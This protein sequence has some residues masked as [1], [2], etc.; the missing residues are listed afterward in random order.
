MTVAT[1]HAAVPLGARLG[2]D[3]LAVAVRSTAATAIELC[4]ARPGG[5]EQRVALDS[6]GETFRTLIAGIAPGQRYGLRAHGPFDPARGHRFD[7]GRLLL[8]PYAHAIDGAYAIVLADLPEACTSH[9]RRAWSETVIY[10]AHVRGLTRL[11]PAIAP[12]LRGTYAGLAQPA[13][14]EELLALG[15]TAIELMPTF[16][17]RSEQHLLQA[18]RANYW[19]YSPVGFLA[20]HAAYA[21]SGAGGGQVAEFRAMTDALH[22][23]GIEVICDVVVNHTAEGGPDQ[24]ALCLRGLDNAGYY[25]LDPGDRSRYADVT[26][27]GNTLDP[28]SAAVQQLVL[29]ALRH[30]VTVL[31]VDGFRFDLAV[32]LGR[33]RDGFSPD[34]PLLQA[35]GSDPALAGTKLIAEPW[36]LG[37]GGYRVGGFPAPFAEWNGIFRDSV[38]EVWRGRGPTSELA[39]AFAGSSDVFSASGRGP[40]ASI[41]LVTSHDGFTLRD[42]VSYDVKQNLAN[43]EGNRDGDDHNR[44]WNG[45]WEGP[46]DDRAIRETRDRRSRAMLATVLLSAGV[47]LL[48]AG[49]ERGR[50][51][52]GN[53][54]PYCHD[55]P[56]TW[57]QWPGDATTRAL[58]RRL[59]ALRAAHPELRRTAFFTGEAGADGELDVRWLTPDGRTMNADWWQAA[60][61]PTLG[62]LLG[63]ALLIVAHS[64]DQPTTVAL[65]ATFDVALDTADPE[66]RERGLRGSLAIAPWSVVVLTRS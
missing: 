23:A 50:T 30:W 48:T 56:L 52:H 45:G 13:I 44:S 7:P 51:Q 16:E 63:G 62:V 19:G 29:D 1:D 5:R 10:E 8:D 53:N 14:I 59:S 37:P 36:D 25:R 11:H 58:V 46:T 31:G 57:L 21:A 55:S 42:L 6:D 4:L 15:I 43:G 33:D 28:S 61:V 65:P 35:I 24:P 64:D 47:P 40:L 49:D 22:T 18:G 3:G 54:N 41:N 38:R 27:T 20:P 2:P 32:T 34:A 26:G 66:R 60:D 17:Y 12:A 9:P 39:R